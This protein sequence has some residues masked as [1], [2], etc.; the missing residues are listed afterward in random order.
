MQQWIQHNVDVTYLAA[1]TPVCG[2]CLTQKLTFTHFVQCV[3]MFAVRWDHRLRRKFWLKF[4]TLAVDEYK[5]AKIKKKQ[6]EVAKFI[7]MYSMLY[8]HLHLWNV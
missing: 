1:D 3:Q 8:F 5:F 2:M 7:N 6:K 4:S